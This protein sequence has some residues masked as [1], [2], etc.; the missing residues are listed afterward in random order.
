[1]A[2]QSPHH[3]SPSTPPNWL[4]TSLPSDHRAAHTS[5]TSS[6]LGVNRLEDLGNLFNRTVLLRVDANVSPQSDQFEFHPRVKQVASTIDQLTSAGARVIVVSHRTMSP[7]APED[8]ISNKA[9]VRKLKECFPQLSLRLHFHELHQEER[10]KNDGGERSYFKRLYTVVKSLPPGQAIFTENIRLFP[11]EREGR[12]QTRTRRLATLVDYVINDGFGVG[13]RGGHFSVDGLARDIPFERKGL[14]PSALEEWQQVITFARGAAPR[15]VALV[16]GGDVGKF[17]SKLK[18]VIN[19][20]KSDRV[21]LVYL[22]GVFGTSYLHAHGCDLGRTPVSKNTRALEKLKGL[23]QRFPDVRFEIPSEYIGVNGKKELTRWSVSTESGHPRITTCQ[24]CVALDQSQHDF[25]TLFDAHQ[26]SRVVAVGPL[27]YYMKK[28]FHE[29]TSRNYRSL[30]AWTMAHH[31]RM[32]L[33]GGGN[34]MEAL[35]DIPEFRSP[36]TPSIMVS[37]GGGALLNALAEVFKSIET[38]HRIETPSIQAL[39]E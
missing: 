17:E 9:I 3:L 19:M 25:T 15:S 16:L 5:A 27:G 24:E 18:L 29:G 38:E 2:S 6:A 33:V 20:L 22:G 30:A 34:S 37:S 28:P 39:R 14:G 1:M 12:L 35:L 23:P 26:I 31:E 8:E 11:V 32:L 4:E 21:G 36:P 10:S 13:H 7:D